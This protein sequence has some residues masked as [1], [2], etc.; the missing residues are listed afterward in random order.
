[1]PEIRIFD[2]GWRDRRWKKS[3]RKLQKDDERIEE[4]LRDL[5][6]ALQVCTH[7]ILD[8]GLQRWSPTS[9][10]A[11]GRQRRLGSW[12]EYRLGDRNNRARVIACH[13]PS[14]G[15]IYLVARTAIHDHR[16]LAEVVDRF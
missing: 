6:S 12:C 14:E 16:R 13:D 5:I 11:P 1:M 8:P 7:P 3:L 15:V 4:S 2:E 9:W 10:H